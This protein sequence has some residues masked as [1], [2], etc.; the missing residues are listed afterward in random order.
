VKKL[1]AVLLLAVFAAIAPA[2]Q[3]ATAQEANEKKAASTKEFRWH[4]R[5]VRSNKDM[6]TLDVRKGHIERVVHYDSSTKWTKVNTETIQPSDVKDGDVVIVL[7]YYNEK[8][9]FI[10]TRIDLRTPKML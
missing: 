6:S 8:K 3:N 2:V 4:G 10:A 1:M 7:G 5:I 9:E